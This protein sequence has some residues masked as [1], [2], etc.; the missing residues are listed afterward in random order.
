MIKLSKALGSAAVAGSL[1]LFAGWQEASLAN[2]Y[3]A[4]TVRYSG[5]ATVLRASAGV[6][7][8]TTKVLLADTGELDSN[9]TSKD[10]TVLT[11]DNPPPLE[12]HSKTAHAIA[13][14]ANNVSAATAAVEKLVVN[15][16]ALK[17]TADV[18][19]ADSMAE[20]RPKSGTVT[21]KG[22][23]TILNLKINGS[24]IDVSRPPNSVTN[25]PGVAKIII[26]EQSHPDVNSIVVNAVHI[27]VPGAPGVVNADVVIS[28]A[29]SGILTCTSL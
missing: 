19:E 13:A 21:S 1:I 16:G 23:S 8:S 6:L 22:T 12:V 9:G 4:G 25:I 20:C 29:E 24:P 10:A 5:R 26:N 28:H 7:T 2:V 11:F 18:I 15:V 17:I 27:I 14:G 3:P